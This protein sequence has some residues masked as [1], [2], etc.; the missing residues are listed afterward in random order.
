MGECIS[1]K[2]GKL[3]VCI[4]PRPLNKALKREHFQ[5]PVL[6]DLF[7]ELTEGKVFSTLDLRDGFW[8][9]KM[10]EASIHLTTFA[11]PFG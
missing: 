8:H 7:P 10:D 5:L 2:N 6:E 3:R 9:L 1:K 11:T 4:D